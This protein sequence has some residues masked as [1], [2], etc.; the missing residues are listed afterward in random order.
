MFLKSSGADKDVDQAFKEAV[1]AGAKVDMP[2]ADMFWGDRYGRPTDPL[3]HSWSFATHKED[4]SPEELK[5]RADAA[6]AKMG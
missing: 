2:F 1:A 6:R 3:G 4:L 5:K